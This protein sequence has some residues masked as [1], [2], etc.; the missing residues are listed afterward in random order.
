MYAR[1]REREKK[2]ASIEACMCRQG[3]WINKSLTSNKKVHS[4]GNYELGNKISEL[5]QF[6][7]FSC[8]TGVSGGW[9]SGDDKH[10]RRVWSRTLEKGGKR[11]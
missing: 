2:M 1:A 7:F 9:L 6:H 10:G 8:S 5:W 11:E 3:D 4:P